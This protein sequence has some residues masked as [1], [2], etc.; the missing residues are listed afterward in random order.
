[1]MTSHRREA[2]KKINYQFVVPDL[3]PAGLT[4]EGHKRYD[5]AFATVIATFLTMLKAWE[6]EAFEIPTLSLDTSYACSSDVYYRKYLL[7]HG[8]RFAGLRGLGWTGPLKSWEF[9]SRY[10][11]FRILLGSLKGS[12]EVRSITKFRFVPRYPILTVASMASLTG[13]FS[14][15]EDVDLRMPEDHRNLV[16]RR[17]GR[18][19]G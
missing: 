8:R 15:L 2:L 7:L 17:Q 13:K 11:T 6:S 4:N 14:A 9:K 12:P 3:G 18:Y 5:D 19:G 16:E 1:M 10:S